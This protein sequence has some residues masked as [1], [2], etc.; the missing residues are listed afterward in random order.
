MVEQRERGKKF[1]GEW[2]IPLG[3]LLG[4]QEILQKKAR[5]RAPWMV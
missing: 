3:R 4:T 1:F 2:N 5:E